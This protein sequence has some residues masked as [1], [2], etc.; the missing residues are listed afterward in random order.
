MK[1]QNVV[2]TL[3]FDSFTLDCVRLEIY[4]CWTTNLWVLNLGHSIQL[5]LAFILSSYLFT[6]MAYK[7]NFKFFASKSSPFCQK[8]ML[9][10]LT[11]KHHFLLSTKQTLVPFSFSQASTHRFTFTFTFVFIYKFKLFIFFT[12]L[13]WLWCK[14]M[15]GRKK[16]QKKKESRSSSHM[17][18]LWGAIVREI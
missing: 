8:L 13:D 9:L 1:W 11:K 10:F 18:Q 2:W 4:A 17:K 12:Y 14:D 7:I 5:H 15:E 3:T 16:K 6:L